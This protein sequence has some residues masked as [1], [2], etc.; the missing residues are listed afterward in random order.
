MNYI[1]Y[2]HGFKNL[3]ELLKGRLFYID[4]GKNYQQE[5]RA[6]SINF[7]LL[8]DRI[9]HEVNLSQSKELLQIADHNLIKYRRRENFIK[10]TYQGSSNFIASCSLFRIVYIL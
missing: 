4:F 6:I 5:R 8:L 7:D 10:V 1:S 3:P 9:H 2:Y